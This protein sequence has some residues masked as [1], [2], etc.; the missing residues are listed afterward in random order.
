MKSITDPPFYASPTNADNSTAITDCLNAN[1][2]GEIVEVPA[3]IFKITKP[4]TVS[5][6]DRL[7]LTGPG[8]IQRDGGSV[9]PGVAL[10]LN[11]GKDSTGAATIPCRLVK[12][13]GVTFVNGGIQSLASNGLRIDA[14]IRKAPVGVF[15]EKSH[16]VR[17]RECDIAGMTSQIGIVNNSPDTVIADNEIRGC[18]VAIRT[19]VA[20]TRISGNHLFPFAEDITPIG[21]PMKIGIH[22]KGKAKF[23][24]LLSIGPDNYIDNATECFIKSDEL[25]SAEMVSIDMNRFLVVKP[26]VTLWEN[27]PVDP[28][29]Q[30]IQYHNFTPPRT[31]SIIGTP[32]TF[33]S[34]AGNEKP[35]KTKTKSKKK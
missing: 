7:T 29:R 22:L 25:L 35:K 33:N 21:G 1:K 31:R 15:I 28:S 14:F 23:A 17:I 19:F 18:G 2:T 27:V 26:N 9:K 13:T 16:D 11:K 32:T 20:A 10:I 30:L 3:G 4:V 8:T 6:A 34:N 24:N 5:G 12:I